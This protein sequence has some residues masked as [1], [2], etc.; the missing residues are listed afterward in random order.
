[1]FYVGLES[2]KPEVE[3]PVID[4][5]L[6]PNLVNTLHQKYPDLTGKGLTLAIHE[7]KFDINDID[8]SNRVIEYEGA[9]NQISR[10]ATEMT[11]IA[12][13]EGNS[14][15]TGRGVAKGTAL[16]SSDFSDI[17]PDPASFYVDYNVSVQNHSFGTEIENFYGAF[18]AEYDKNVN[19][20]NT[21][22]HV[23]SSGNNGF[24]SATEGIYEGISGIA[25]LTGNYKQAKNVLT[26][27][28][29]DTVFNFP[30]FVSRGPAYDGRIKPE[31]V[32]YS[33][34]G[35]SNST[36]LLSGVCILIQQRFLQKFNELPSFSSVKSILMASAED[37]G[38]PGPDYHSG[39]G[40][41]NAYEA[42]KIVENENIH[43]DSLS[44]NEIRTFQ[45]EIPANV[46]TIR[47]ALSWIDVPAN[48]GDYKALVNDLDIVIEGPDG[49]LYYPGVP[50]PTPGSEILERNVSTGVDTLNNGELVSI[51]NPEP[52]IYSVKVSGDLLVG[53]Q[54]IYSVAWQMEDKDMFEW[55]A[56]MKDE[57]MP[58]NGESA[59]YFRWNST[60]D[61]SQGQLIVKW[62]D[63][64]ETL[65]ENDLDI[66]KGYYRWVPPDTLASV[67][68]VVRIN[69]IDYPSDNF[70]ISSPLRPIVSVN[71]N[72]SLLIEWKPVPGSDNYEVL[73]FDPL[74]HKYRSTTI[75]ADTF[76][77]IQSN[78]DNNIFR[79]FPRFNNYT[80]ISGQA[81]NTQSQI[82][83]CFLNSFFATRNNDLN[84]IDLTVFLGSVYSI[85]KIRFFRIGA[86]DELINELGK[87]QLLSRILTINDLDPV[88]GINNYYAR[89]LFDN[90]Q[91]IDSEIASEYYINEKPVMVFPNPATEG[92]EVKI[93]TRAFSEKHIFSLISTSGKILFERELFPERDFLRINSVPQGIY[94]YRVTGSEFNMTGKLIIY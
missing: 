4:L 17:I 21:L 94:L 11:T 36:A 65:I 62:N 20:I 13:G 48:P 37:I 5:N 39:Y 31:L 8:F 22:I 30:E 80:G 47:V 87:E 58:Y 51:N 18:A 59:S 3:T 1:M 90:G 34:V 54:Q 32:T 67:M 88:E 15:I 35:S 64:T 84:G 43:V 27:G 66:K 42:I 70:V 79:V 33:N 76:A 23:F 38:I 19:N 69:G 41:V 73:T 46:N 50:D 83:S 55:N 86:E 89:I 68:A 45:L 63:G 25:N 85:N 74:L 2:T 77:V 53:D 10:H 29:A 60:L 24:D 40:N 26:I 28:S 9:S 7:E 61:D 92:D 81:I 91:V 57:N 93:F 6:R 72:D 56:P 71:C 49:A 78:D 44:D 82:S 52:G 75:T 12:A 16:V 14:F